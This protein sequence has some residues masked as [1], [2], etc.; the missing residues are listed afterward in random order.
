MGKFKPNQRPSMV[1]GAILTNPVIA[2]ALQIID[3]LKRC[4]FGFFAR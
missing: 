3:A 4:A 1:I 2:A